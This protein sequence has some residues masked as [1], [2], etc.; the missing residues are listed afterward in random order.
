MY[1]SYCLA[2]ALIVALA[3]PAVAEQQ[4]INALVWCDHTD[5]AFLKGFTEETGIKVNHKVF[6]GTGAGLAILEQSRPGD[7]DVMVVDSTDVR[8]VVGRGL[9]APLNPADFDLSGVPPAI[10]LPQHHTIDGKVYALPEKYGYNAIAFDKNKIDE[11]TAADI[12]TLWNPKYKGQIAIYDYYLPLITQVAVAL[13]LNPTAITKADLPAIK[14]VLIK[15]RKNA[16]VVGDVVT[17]QTALATGR[18]AMIAGGGEYIVSGLQ[19]SQPNLEWVL[20]TVGS[21]RWEQAIAILASSTKKK[22]ATKF[23]QYTIS[24]KGQGA[25]ATSSCYWGMPAN[26]RAPLTDKQKKS[27]R[28]DQ[29]NAYIANSHPYISPTEEFDAAMQDMWAEVIQR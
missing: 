28:Y 23:L 1:R 27:L 14:E 9:L 4:E 18:V 26:S 29:Q 21:T 13:G 3:Q 15:M 22:E 5:D 2:L 24:P 19:A 11:A 12:T 7:W 10:Q 16:A 20:P 6:E 17:S 25:L 8:R